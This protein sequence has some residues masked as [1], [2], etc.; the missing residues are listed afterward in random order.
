[1]AISIPESEINSGVRASRLSGSFFKGGGDNADKNW[2]QE[3]GSDLVEKVKSLGR[4]IGK[5]LK[6]VV[7]GARV[8]FEKV[9]SGDWDFFKRWFDEAPLIP[10]LAGTGAALLTGAVVIFAGGSI[11]GS[12]VGGI[13]GLVA[14]LGLTNSILLAGAMPAIMGT[15][16]NAGEWAYDFDWATPDISLIKQCKDAINNI[17]EPLGESMGQALAAIVVGR[18]GRTAAPAVDVD[19]TMAAYF[20]IINPS[21]QDQIIDALASLVS[22]V[23]SIAYE[24][25]FLQ[26][27]KGV[28]QIAAKLTGNDEWGEEGQQPFIIS[29]KV[30][31][32]Y[33]RVKASDYLGHISDEQWEGIEAF[34]ESFMETLK[35]LLQ[36]E[37]TYTNWIKR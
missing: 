34:G 25:L 8:V 1:M 17:W 32:V 5:Y 21:L 19:L 12:A 23:K 16:I 36:E 2:L 9:T 20:T 24:I 29:Q 15:V 7:G 14:S 11:V 18:F 31:R 27:Y 30:E 22:A 3:V 28:R 33:E 6:S 37:D 10:K 26:T 13:K 35:D 4:D